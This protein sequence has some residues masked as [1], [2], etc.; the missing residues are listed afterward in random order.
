MHESVSRRRASPLYV[1]IFVLV[2]SLLFFLVSPARHA[3][4]AVGAPTPLSFG[5]RALGQAATMEWALYMTR[6][7][8]PRSATASFWHDIALPVQHLDQQQVVPMVVEIPRGTVAKMEINKER[9]WNP[10]V[11]DTKAGRLREYPMPSVVHYGAVPRTFEHPSERDDFTGLLGDGDPVDIVDLSGL[12]AAPG[13]VVWVRVVGALAME[14]DGA[15][16]WKIIAVRADDRRL[17]GITGASGEAGNSSPARAD[18]MFLPNPTYYAV[19]CRPCAH[20]ASS[21]WSS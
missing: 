5:S 4:P 1:G 21:Q 9:A 13:Q 8:L 20:H 11:Q 14:D 19:P 18:G 10:I 6:S 2:G 3:L 7:H 12:P 16:D 17:A 15:A